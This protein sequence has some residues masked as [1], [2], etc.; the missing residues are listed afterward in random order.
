MIRLRAPRSNVNP[1]SASNVGPDELAPRSDVRQLQPELSDEGVPRF[2]RVEPA[3][4]PIAATSRAC[5]RRASRAHNE[6]V[7]S[8]VETRGRL[9]GS[10]IFPGVPDFPC[11]VMEGKAGLLYAYVSL[12]RP[13]QSSFLGYD[14]AT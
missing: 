14:G 11:S 12:Q 5:R 3:A 8:D 7:G 2:M 9:T 1:S 6:V 13:D 10:A 4:P